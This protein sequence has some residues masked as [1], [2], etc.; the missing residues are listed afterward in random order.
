MKLNYGSYSVETSGNGFTALIRRN[1]DDAEFF[2]QGEESTD[3]LD[4]LDALS[5]LDAST[6]LT[7]SFLSDYFN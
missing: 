7:D 4:A 5:A 3:L 1:S 6:E 2:M